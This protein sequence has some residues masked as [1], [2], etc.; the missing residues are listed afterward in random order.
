[1][2]DSTTAPSPEPSS[3][4]VRLRDVWDL[5]SEYR[6][7][8]G[9]LAA[10]A[11]VS[12]ISS[13]AEAATIALVAAIALAVSGDD[14]VTLDFGTIDLG[15]G[16]TTGALWM[17]AAAVLVVTVTRVVG[18]FIAARLST[19]GVV[20]ARQ[21]VLGAYLRTSWEVQEEE[22]AGHVHELAS[23][24]AMRVSQTFHM[25][26][27][28]LMSAV[29]FVVLAG[30]AAL[31]APIAAASMLGLTGILVVGLRPLV[32]LTRTTSRAHL[33]GHNQVISAIEEAT[34]VTA[35]V[36]VF[37]VIDAMQARVGRAIIDV[38]KP[39]RRARFLSLVVPGLMVSATMGA[40]V[41]GLAVINALSVVEPLGLGVAVLFLLRNMRYAQG[42]Q[43]GAQFIV[44]Q[45]PFLEEL[46]ESTDRYL[47]ASPPVRGSTPLTTID[48]IEL[49][50]VT[51]QYPSGEQALRGVDLSITAGEVIGVVGPSGGGK[52]TLVQVLLGLRA[53]S[54][55]TVRVSGIDLSEARTDDWHSLIAYVGQ[56][57]RLISGDVRDNVR[58]F[59]PSVTDAD[60]DRAIE[61]AALSRDLEKW[62]ADSSRAV[63]EAG[64][65]LSGGQRQR[66]ALARAFAGNPQLIV[67][68]E[69]TSAL[70]VT[71]ERQIQHALAAL[72]TDVT[73]VLVAHRPSTLTVCDRLL[74]MEHGQVSEA[75]R[76][77]DE[78]AAGVLLARVT[79]GTS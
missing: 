40:L 4:R 77:D 60:I 15:T 41:G 34:E 38:A 75:P 42:A 2:S 18:S 27:S 19:L 61:A 37:G 71:S 21:K 1:M 78:A 23:M 54:S 10:F 13:L 3:G 8:R 22:S 43:A 73:V 7:A 33:S 76:P 67:L 17:G 5:L 57:P 58:F 20:Q 72:P 46:R 36:R 25:M 65:E 66:I 48:R 44:E 30:A 24:H 45:W 16:S 74:V 35:E 62:T 26:S 70:D 31:A 51:Y 11:A 50:G 69:P 52:T 9:H 47:R 12:A 32:S 64:R 14:T 28:V 39:H 56:Q 59:R 63:G 68:D 6:G 79:S 53:P 49:S 29:G 55:G